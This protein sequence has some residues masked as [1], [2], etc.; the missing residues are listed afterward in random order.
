M[1]YAA[2]C[3]PGTWNNLKAFQKGQELHDI[4][5]LWIEFMD[6]IVVLYNAVDILQNPHN[7]HHIASHL[8]DYPG[9]FQELHWK[10]MGAPRYIHGILTGIY[11]IC[12]IDIWGFFGV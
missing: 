1:K 6:Y 3:F 2:Q 12:D 11:V 7:N 4:L 8:S 5:Y 9:Y 10:S